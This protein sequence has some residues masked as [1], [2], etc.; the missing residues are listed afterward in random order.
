MKNNYRGL[1]Y[2]S[3]LGCILVLLATPVFA[4]FIPNPCTWNNN[5][6][7]GVLKLCKVAGYGIHPNPYFGFTFSATPNYYIAPVMISA[8]PAPDVNCKISQPIP[9]NTVVKITEMNLAP[10]AAAVSNINVTQATD[11]VVMPNLPAGTVSVKIENNKVT[12]VTYRDHTDQGGYLEICKQ[13]APGPP[14]T[15]SFTYTITGVLTPVTVQAG[16]CSPPLEV[17]AGTLLITEIGRSGITMQACTV[18]PNLN[19]VSGSCHPGPVSTGGS[20]KVNVVAGPMSTQTVVI[21]TN[22]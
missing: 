14:L 20:V 13:A 15:G 16:Y 4:Q 22:L 2:A 1:I 12:E 19:S 21:F 9:M 5:Q 3:I 10:L 18:F 11:I 7:C 8:S 17:P 6:G